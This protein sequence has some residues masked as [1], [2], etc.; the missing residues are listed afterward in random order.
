MNAAFTSALNRYHSMMMLMI[1]PIGRFSRP[2]MAKIMARMRAHFF[3]VKSPTPT[4]R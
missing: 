4:R 1:V 2:M 3:S